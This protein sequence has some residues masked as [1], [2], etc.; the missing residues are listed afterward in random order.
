MS[1][2]GKICLKSRQKDV[3]KTIKGD[4]YQLSIENSLLSH[5]K[6]CQ[7]CAF[8]IPGSKIGCE[9]NSYEICCAWVNLYSPDSELNEKEL[10]DFCRQNIDEYQVPKYIF[11]RETIPQTF[12]GKY[13]RSEMKK[14]TIEEL[15]KS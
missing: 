12:C 7:A 5:P 8:G 11:F 4:V 6:V 2:D 14:L 9:E 3:I 13:M 15:N 10:I 1:Q